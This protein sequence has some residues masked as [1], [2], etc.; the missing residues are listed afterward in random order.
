MAYNKTINLGEKFKVGVKV[1]TIKA[2][3]KKINGHYYC[4][5]CNKQLNTIKWCENCNDKKKGNYKLINQDGK[6]I[7]IK[8]FKQQL[9]NPNEISTLKPISCDKIGY[10][11]IDKCYILTPQKE[12]ETR[13]NYLY[14]YLLFYNKVLPIEKYRN[15][16]NSFESSGYI[17]VKYGYMFLNIVVEESIAKEIQPYERIDIPKENLDKFNKLLSFKDTATEEDYIKVLGLI[18]PTTTKKKQNLD[19]D[20][21]KL[22]EG[23]K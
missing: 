17:E 7:N 19:D 18:K 12:S 22:I 23:S 16:S 14:N 9:S 11:P 1:N 15:N 8:D 3:S 6:E 4:E 2:T 10:Q 5:T 13:F 20:F 21:V